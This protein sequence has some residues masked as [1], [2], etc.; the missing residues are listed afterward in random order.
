MQDGLLV[1]RLLMFIS[2]KS[3]TD[4]IRGEKVLY[5]YTAVSII[6]LMDHCLYLK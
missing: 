3:R 5:E 6:Y 4:F 1:A 2:R